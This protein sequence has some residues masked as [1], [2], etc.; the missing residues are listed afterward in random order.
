MEN[1]SGRATLDGVTRCK[2]AVC[3]LLT[4]GLACSPKTPGSSEPPSTKQQ[5]TS[6]P[7]APSANV[8]PPDPREAALA[9]TVL[10]LLETQHLLQKKIGD[11]ISREAFTSYLERLDGGK[12]FLLKADHDALASHRDKMDDELRSGSLDLAHDGAKIYAA[13]VAQ[14][15]KIVTAA[16]EKPMDFSNEEWFELDAEKLQPAATEQDLAERWRRRLEL[17][18]LER[19]A[20]MEDRLKP[21]K[22]PKAKGDKTD[23]KDKDKDADEKAMPISQIPP[24]PEGR[25]AKAR[26]D[27]AKSYSGR[28]ARLKAPGPLDAAADFVNAI[29]S[30]LDPHTT[31]LPPAD[32]ANFDIQMSGS[33]EGIGAVLRERDHY[34]EV[35]EIVPGGA[36][37]KQGK[38]EQGDLILAVA[39]DNQ[40][41]VDVVDM[42]I[43]EVVKMIRGKTGTVVRL[44]VQKP[45]GTEET[46]AITRDVVIVEETYARGAILTRKNQQ[47]LGYIHL[48]SFYGGKGSPREAA[49]DVSFLLTEM[50]KARVP[51]VVIDLRSNG[52]GILGDAIEM[53]ARSSIRARW[54]RSRTTMASARRCPTRT[55]A[56]PTTATS[57]C[58]S[59]SSAPR[60]RRSWPA[61]SRTT[62]AR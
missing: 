5:P 19:V 9:A 25:E 30:T 8:P 52:G 4:L 26:A 54:S 48:P 17:E 53:T 18:V 11:D 33:L 37:W 27:L 10:R 47:P 28:F 44:R 34:I 23:D 46:I 51:G 2:T 24:T 40:D 7:L 12:M 42:R 20:G 60:R 14:V 58:W 61:R 3:F 13:R 62:A 35:T 21:K 1:D 55:R 36:S 56:S 49:K 15:E 45:T 59:T 32:K 31:Y 16:L 22:D 50:K 43:D 57:C 6:A 29:A 41:A 39:Q 38:L